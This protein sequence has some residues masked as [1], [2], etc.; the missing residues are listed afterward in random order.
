MPF[1]SVIRLACTLGL[2]TVLS[3]CAAGRSKDLNYAPTNFGAPDAAYSTEAQALYRIGPLDTLTINVFEVPDLSGDRQVDPLGNVAM[4]L[5]GDVSA[6]GKTAKEF[7]TE[8]QAR[9]GKTY[10]QSPR[11]Q[12]LVKDAVS[13]RITVDGSVGQPGIYPIA[14]RTTLIQ[15]IATA[16]GLNDK[17][18]PHRVVVFRRINGQRQAAGFDLQSIREG[19]MPDPELFG[20]DIVVVDGNTRDGPFKTLLQSVPL[21]AL[22][23]PF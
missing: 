19:K 13:Q 14:G 18:N 23:R 4:P 7:E 2:A 9:L 16:R 3:A 15:A 21:L 10:L 5:I 11:V 17:A 6:Q 12:V 20:N 1:L 22:F 8:L